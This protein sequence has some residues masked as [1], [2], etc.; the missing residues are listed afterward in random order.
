[1][2]VHGASEKNRHK[3]RD[4]GYEKIGMD[5]SG[6]ARLA[7][8]DAA[9][10]LEMIDVTLDGG[11]NL[12]CFD[13]FIG[14]ANSAR[15]QSEVAFRIDISHSA[16]LGISTG[17]ITVTDPM[18]LAII[19]FVPRH[20]W[21]DELKCRHSTSEMRSVAFRLHR[22]SRVM[23][24]TRHAM[25]VQWTLLTIGTAARVQRNESL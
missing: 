15:I 2:L 23:R 1:M 11:S 19:A 8:T 21:A 7:V 24:T 4:T 16:G 18:V 5:R 14:T 17:V 9:A 22:K 13:P 10:A 3:L 12:V 25:L 6:I 20:F